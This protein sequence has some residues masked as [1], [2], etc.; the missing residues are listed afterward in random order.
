MDEEKPKRK[1][2][3]TSRKAQK[4]EMREMRAFQTKLEI[5]STL[6]FLESLKFELKQGKRYEKAERLIHKRPYPR[7]YI[8]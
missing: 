1:P 5:E 2:T 8:I 3:S 7:K 6:A 4:K